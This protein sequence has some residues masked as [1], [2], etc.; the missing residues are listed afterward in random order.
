MEGSKFYCIH[1]YVAHIL[2]NFKKPF[3]NEVLLSFLF[4]QTL[5]HELGH[6]YKELNTIHPGKFPQEQRDADMFGYKL[7]F[8]TLERLY[9][10]NIL[11]WILK[12]R[13]FNIK[14]Q[15]NFLSALL[16]RPTSTFQRLK[17][18]LIG[19]VIFTVLGVFFFLWGVI[20]GKFGLYSLSKYFLYTMFGYYILFDSAGLKQGIVMSILG[21]FCIWEGMSKFS[22]S[23]YRLFDLFPGIIFVYYGFK[24][25]HYYFFN[26]RKEILGKKDILNIKLV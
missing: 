26:F 14:L 22:I 7:L 16:R 12:K 3:R 5:C 4:G 8:T 25:L 2:E 18:D 11:F 6:H 17:Q 21:L 19:G 13:L 20:S 1:I 15:N 10:F 24:F 9:R 23:I